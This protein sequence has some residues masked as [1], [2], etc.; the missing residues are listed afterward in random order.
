MPLGDTKPKGSIR[1][2]ILLHQC[3]VKLFS[4]NTNSFD[5]LSNFW[6]TLPYKV[7]SNAQ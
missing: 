1:E 3:E 6:H 7:Q 5:L 4:N 2:N